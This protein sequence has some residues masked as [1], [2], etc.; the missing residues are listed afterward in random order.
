MYEVVSRRIT[1]QPT[2]VMNAKLEMTEIPTFLGRAYAE[3]ATYLGRSGS[4][5]GGPPFARFRRLDDVFC[6]VEAG[7]PVLAP[8]NGQGALIASTLPGGVAAV[9]TYFGPYDGMTPAYEA[10]ETWVADRG[11]EPDGP[12][13]EVYFTDP[14]EQPDPK[15]WKTEIVQPYTVL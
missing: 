5:F 6:E 13:W 8:V 15:T 14:A 4:E 2:L 3:V 1:E 10:I 9:V 7:F 11:A 12:A